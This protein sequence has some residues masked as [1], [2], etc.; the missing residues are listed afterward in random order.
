MKSGNYSPWPNAASRETNAFLQPLL[1]RQSIYGNC[2][3]VLVG[4]FLTYSGDQNSCGA[5]TQVV[6]G[7]SLRSFWCAPLG[8]IVVSRKDEGIALVFPPHL[9]F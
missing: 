5:L 4:A 1:S 6:S 3:F 9:Q 8:S 2:H 7:L